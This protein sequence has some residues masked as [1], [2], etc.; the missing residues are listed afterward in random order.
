MVSYAKSFIEAHLADPALDTSMVAAAHHVS[1][2]Y[3]QKL[4]EA[5]GLTVAGWIRT[6]RLQRCHRD[7]HDPMLASVRIGTIGVR[8][9]FADANHFSRLFQQAYGVSPRSLPERLHL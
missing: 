7:L 1:P 3:L 8:H 9:G 5:E 4:F 2:R 6:R